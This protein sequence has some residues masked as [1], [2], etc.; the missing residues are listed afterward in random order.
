M[1]TRN[2]SVWMYTAIV[3]GVLLVASC[4]NSQKKRE[5]AAERQATEQQVPTGTIVE[6]ETVVVEVDS[7]VP[8]TM[9][10]RNATTPGNTR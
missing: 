6:S 4:G 5:R 9:T 8:D 10:G 7:I 2:S 3:A 1:K